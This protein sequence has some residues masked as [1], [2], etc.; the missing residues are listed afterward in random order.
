M[1]LFRG[2]ALIQVLLI[3]ALLSIFALYVKKLAIEQVNVAKLSQ[4]K[5][6]ALV[7]SHSVMSEVL[8]ALLVNDT[9]KFSNN[10]D[11]DDK[12]IVNKIRFSGVPFKV[13]NTS[14]K[15]QD[16]SGLFNIH[17]FYKKHFI[18][19]FLENGINESRAEELWATIVDWQD[20][21]EISSIAGVEKSFNEF[22]VRNGK[23]SDITEL[24]SIIDLTE[25]EKELLYQN[26]SIF[27]IGDLNLMAA[28]KD[29]LGA[30]IG[31]ELANQIVELRS[32]NNLTVKNFR[33]MTGITFE[34]DYRFT[35]SSRLGFELVTH[36]ND[37]KYERELVLSLSPYAKKQSLPINILLDRK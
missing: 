10:V 22:P 35:P 16:Q 2:I 23:I 36:I 1:F 21:N 15:V 24:E 31:G 19:L 30:I 20:E 13:A 9:S 5:A 14:V 32:S 17:F 28:S 3:V 11:S 7:E 26:F 37:V 33:E 34:T 8:F 12:T 25:V 27:S 29:V 6:Q 18:N 4:D